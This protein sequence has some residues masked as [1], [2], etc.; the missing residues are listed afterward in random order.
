MFASAHHPHSRSSACVGFEINTGC[1]GVPWGKASSSTWWA[2][3]D[4]RMSVNRSLAEFFHLPDLSYGPVSKEGNKGC[5]NCIV[6]G[7]A[8]GEGFGML[9]GDIWGRRVGPGP[10]TVRGLLKTT[11]WPLAFMPGGALQLCAAARLSIVWSGSPA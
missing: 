6:Q 3:R 1:V 5:G 8:K 2:H 4:G 9:H 11:G 10:D 7:K